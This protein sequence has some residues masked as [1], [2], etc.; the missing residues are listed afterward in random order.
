MNFLWKTKAYLDPS[1]N[2]DIDDAR[3]IEITKYR[4]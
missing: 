3:S 4:F 2:Y 1:I